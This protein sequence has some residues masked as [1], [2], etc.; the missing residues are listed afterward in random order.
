MI[1]FE[2]IIFRTEIKWKK[3]KEKEEKKEPK[4]REEMLDER[5]KQK[6]DRFC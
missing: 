4:T 1:I 2:L 3:I 6:H 5:Q